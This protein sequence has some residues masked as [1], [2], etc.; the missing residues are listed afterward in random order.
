M[1]EGS[2]K[3]LACLG[4][5]EEEVE[6]EVEVGGVFVEETVSGGEVDPSTSRGDDKVWGR[7]RPVPFLR[8]FVE[9]GGD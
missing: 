7:R 1:G 6:V 9:D 4:V 2:Q 3:T 8:S 5:G